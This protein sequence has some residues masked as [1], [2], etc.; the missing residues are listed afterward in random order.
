MSRL[1]RP[2][3]LVTAHEPNPSVRAF[4]H[5]LRTRHG[6]QVIYSDRS[7]FTGLPIL[8]ALRRHEVVGVQMEPWGSSRGSHTVEFFGRPMRFQLGPFAVARVA[9]APIVPVFALRTGIR[10]YV[11]RVV[12]RFDPTT[13]A[14]SAAALEATVRAY[15]GL[16]REAPSQWLMFE[17][18]WR[19]GGAA[20]PLE[21]DD[22]AFVS[23]RARA[24]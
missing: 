20:V 3:S 19:D 17:D 18:V 23:A 5:S 13:P 7:V 24:R 21:A 9:R 10:Q 12:G 22:T 1:G 2:V 15:E 8:Q 11:L 14:E 4:V 16:V 6:F